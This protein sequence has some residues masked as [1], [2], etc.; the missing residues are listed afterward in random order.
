VKELST[1]I[2]RP[3]YS[4]VFISWSL[5]PLEFS[6]LGHVLPAGSSPPYFAFYVWSPQRCS[7]LPCILDFIKELSIDLLA[8]FSQLNMESG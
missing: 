2:L 6:R 5:P 3:L 8:M 4:N 7:Q 1:P